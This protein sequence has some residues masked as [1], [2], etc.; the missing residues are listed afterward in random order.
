MKTKLLCNE[1]LKA[2]NALA[3]KYRQLQ[4]TSIHSFNSS[5]GIMKRMDDLFDLQEAIKQFD[6]LIGYAKKESYTWDMISLITDHEDI[7][8]WEAKTAKLSDWQDL[9]KTSKRNMII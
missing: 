4:A 5:D 6:I 2:R 8:T 9:T 7:E 1:L 3:A